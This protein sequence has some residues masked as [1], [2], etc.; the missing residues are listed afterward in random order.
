MKIAGVHSSLR[1]RKLTWHVLNKLSRI[2]LV[3][4]MK[5]ISLATPVGKPGSPFCSGRALITRRALNLMLANGGGSTVITMFSAPVLLTNKKLAR[6]EKSFTA[7][8]NKEVSKC[9][10]IKTF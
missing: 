9:G 8:L 2:G 5:T 6:S 4:S 10:K 3:S 7:A 1:G